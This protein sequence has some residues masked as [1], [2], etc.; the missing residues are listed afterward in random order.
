MEAKE[1]DNPDDI[2]DIFK[3]EDNLFDYKKPLNY[4]EYELNNN[5]TRDLEE[6]WLNNGVP[7]QLCDHIC[8]HI[9][10]QYRFKNGM[11]KWSTCSSDIDGVCN[12]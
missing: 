11:T 6:P 2:A 8:Y 9:C 5:V 3:I 12:G 1:D 7:Y 10:E 4:E